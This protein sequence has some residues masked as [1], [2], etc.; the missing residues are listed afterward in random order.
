MEFVISKRHITV[1]AISNWMYYTSRE[2]LLNY[3]GTVAD[4]GRNGNTIYL[5][6]VISGDTVNVIANGKYVDFGSSGYSD[7]IGFNNEKIHL[8]V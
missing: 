7:D 4:C 3:D 6:N 5:N 8:T 1:V 2:A